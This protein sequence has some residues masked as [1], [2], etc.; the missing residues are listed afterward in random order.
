MR[1]ALPRPGGGPDWQRRAPRWRLEALYPGPE[2][3]TLLAD[4]S[5]ADRDRARLF[6]D[7][8]RAVA[9]DKA[10]R[11]PW[12][13][14]DRSSLAG[15]LATRSR[16][17]ADSGASR[18]AAQFA[19]GRPAERAAIAR[20][21]DAA[22][23]GVGAELAQVLNA[24]RGGAA[25]RPA[26]DRRMISVAAAREAPALAA[27]LRPDGPWHAARPQ[28]DTAWPEAIGDVLAALERLHP[29]LA[30]AGRSTLDAGR[31]DA[32]AH[33]AKA[34]AFSHPGSGDGP[35]VCV[36]FT[37]LPASVA[38]L[39]HEMGH[40]AAQTLGNAPDRRTAETHAI[41]A[42]CALM[43]VRAD[44]MGAADA[45]T[46][47]LFVLFVR[48]AAVA[49]FERAFEAEPALD[50][51][52]ISALWQE[53]FAF[54]A[55]HLD[56]TG[57]GRAWTL[58]PMLFATPGAAA[59]YLYA[60]CAAVRLDHALAMGGQAARE[61]Y[62]RLLRDGAPAAAHLAALCGERTM[63]DHV[64]TGFAAAA[65]LSALRA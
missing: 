41:L 2:D 26:S 32:A 9:P 56:W 53:A 7:L 17:L 52:A 1:F 39:A 33:G 65:R 3:P 60:A 11:L 13:L 42:E 47:A 54:C 31:V 20:D 14:Q 25:H 36:N 35:W 51:H 24:A 30:E 59:D 6:A 49:L 45:R 64:T 10:A 55:P 27:R 43:R 22:L 21:L 12:A 61:T 16:L 57:Y 46:E 38:V 62:V 5:G 40:A 63:E 50:P 58:E 34:G 19:G 28:T 8:L 37:G 23:G 15:A 44:R 29:D 18:L 48:M 4:A